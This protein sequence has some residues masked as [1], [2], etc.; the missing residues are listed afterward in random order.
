MSAALAQLAEW[1]VQLRDERR[2]AHWQ[3]IVEARE[4]D[5]SRVGAHRAGARVF[6]TVSGQEGTIAGFASENVLVHAPAE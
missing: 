4:N 6:D 1:L 2:R 3:R 5:A